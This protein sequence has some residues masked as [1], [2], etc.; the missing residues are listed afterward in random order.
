MGHPSFSVR[1]RYTLWLRCGLIAQVTQDRRPPE[2]VSQ[3]DDK[4]PSD[5]FRDHKRS[6]ARH[7]DRGHRDLV[8]VDLGLSRP[9]QAAR[10]S[11][12]F[13]RNLFRGLLLW[14]Q[15]LAGPPCLLADHFHA[16]S[17]SCAGCLLLFHPCSAYSCMAMAYCGT[18]GILRCRLFLGLVNTAVRALASRPASS[19]EQRPA[20]L[21]FRARQ[22]FGS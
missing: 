22:K 4:D 9:P 17:A 13:Y 14:P 11:L 5:V 2:Y 10:A 16:F 3:E 19:L 6:P 15:A 21:N 1:T 12:S 20:E 7:R 8:P 18:A